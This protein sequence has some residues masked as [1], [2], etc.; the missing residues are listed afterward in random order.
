MFED[1]SDFIFS[2][3]QIKKLLSV[4]LIIQVTIFL[5]GLII[6]GF[7]LFQLFSNTAQASQDSEESIEVCQKSPEFGRLTAD[8]GGAVKNPGVYELDVNSRVNDLVNIAGGF[9]S[10]VDKYYINKILNLSKRLSDGEKLYI[11]TFEESIEAETNQ[12]VQEPDNSGPVG[13]LG[14]M[15]SI[16][17]AS[18]DELI[19]LTGIGEKRADD[20]IAERPYDSLYKLVEKGAITDSIFENIKNNIS[21]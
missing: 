14:A 19:G 11:P 2:F 7:G 21:L 15:V 12:L 4:R 16:N 3:T 10:A 9:S 13:S 20:I 18:K 6:S 1:S 17:S 5:S 8:I